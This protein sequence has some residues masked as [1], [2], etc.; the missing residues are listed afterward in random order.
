MMESVTLDLRQGVGKYQWSH[1]KALF[2]NMME[3]YKKNT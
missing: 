1:L 3:N 2:D